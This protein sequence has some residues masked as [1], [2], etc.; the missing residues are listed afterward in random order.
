[1]A[2]DLTATPQ[3]TTEK[4]T[5]F[6]DFTKDL[7]AAV[8]VASAVAGTVTFPTSGTAA[9]SIGAIASNVVPLTVTNPAPAGE[10][11]VSVTA[12]LSDAET[13]VAYLHIPAIWKATRAGMEYLIAELRGMTDTSY[14]DFRVAGVPWW[15]DKHLQ[16]FLDRYRVD[17]IEENLYA[18]Q[19]MRNGTAYTLDYRSQYGNLETVASGTGL[20]KLDNSAG[21][22]MPGTMWSADYQR[23]V[24][25]F[26]SDTAGSSMILTG[27]SYDLPAAAADVWRYKAA[28]AAKMY[29]FSAGGQNFQRNQYY[30]NCI[31]MAQY[32]EG[33]AAPTIISI[34]RG[35]NTMYGVED[36]QYVE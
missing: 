35:D 10:Y 36:E 28:N 9:L 22:N 20:F 27:R 31:A 7:P 13:I 30:Q 34:F 5:H 25:T 33:Q 14:D 12:T 6:I 11:I 16:D 24:V 26:N 21:T 32:Y 17:F 15:S 23:G 4:R 3:A 29:S 8:T 18:I 2:I 1:M 19:Q